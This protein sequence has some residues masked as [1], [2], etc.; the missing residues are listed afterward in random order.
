MANHFSRLEPVELSLAGLLYQTSFTASLAG[1][2]TSFLQIK[3]GS[4]SPLIMGY[5]IESSAEPLKV[6][7]IESPTITDG[8]TAV[9]SRIMNRTKTTNAT[10]LFF[11]DPTSISGGTVLDIVIVTAGKGSGSS[12]ESHGAWKLKTDTSYV[13][14]I[15]QLT[16]QSTII[17]GQIVFA[18]GYGTF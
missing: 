16:N 10:T 13:L 17:A 18:E 2:Q 9:A 3:T 15:E 14:K 6:S 5:E 1:N 4:L 8:T 7:A 11:S 12:A